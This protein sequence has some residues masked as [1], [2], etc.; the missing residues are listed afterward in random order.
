LFVPV[1][2]SFTLTRFAEGNHV[3]AHE[4]GQITYVK[5]S[6]SGTG[7]CV[8]VGFDAKSSSV[9]VR[10]SREPQ[11]PPLLFTAPEWKAFLQGVAAGEFTLG[12]LQA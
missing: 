8:E 1:R 7:D 2:L 4:P 3:S 6:Y 10:N 9:A 5:S 11:M 12:R